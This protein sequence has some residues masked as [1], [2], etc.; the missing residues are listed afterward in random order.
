[1][2]S[3][4]TEICN[5]ALMHIGSTKEIRDL[6]SENSA[7]AR[8]MRRFYDEARREVLRDGGWPFA[9]GIATLALIEED[10]NT[11]WKY[12]YEPPSGSLRNIRIV[13]AG[14]RKEQESNPIPFQLGYTSSGTVLYTDQ[15]SAELE[16][17]ANVE[18]VSRFPPDFVL[19][20]S[21]LLAAYTAPSI[22]NGD[23]FKRR[24]ECLQLY[25]LAMSKARANAKNEGATDPIP[26]SEFIRAR[27]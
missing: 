12:S 15:E 4:K 13:V 2:A 10:P 27:D 5:M 23:S 20:F 18:D 8:A 6:S 7:E 11:Q 1:M 16:Y 25:S 19:A 14:I 17:V 9:N 21:L 24:L 3:S 26:E 22:S